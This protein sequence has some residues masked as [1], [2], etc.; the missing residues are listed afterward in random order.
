[1]LV[2][3]GGGGPRVELQS[4]SGEPVAMSLTDLEEEKFGPIGSP[5]HRNEKHSRKPAIAPSQA[6]TRT[7][8][9]ESLC[10]LA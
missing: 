9:L 8:F 6:D 5:T 2:G 3:G 7:H 4:P 10:P 1:V